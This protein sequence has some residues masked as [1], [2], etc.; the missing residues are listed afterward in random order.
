VVFGEERYQQ[1]MANRFGQ[2]H[3]DHPHNAVT[4]DG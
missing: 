2:V 1:A 4:G 3:V